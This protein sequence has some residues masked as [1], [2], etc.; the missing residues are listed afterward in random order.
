MVIAMDERYFTLD[1]V[2]EQLQVSRRTINRLAATG[3]L[4][5]IRLAPQSGSV[6]VAESDLRK[7]LEERRTRPPNEPP[8]D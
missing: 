7:F 3:A 8:E 4:P 5:V 2:A 6:R 1:Q